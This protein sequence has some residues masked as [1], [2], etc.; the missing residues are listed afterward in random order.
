MLAFEQEKYPSAG[1]RR[2]VRHNNRVP[3][4]HCK[5]LA[6]REALRCYV[7]KKTIRS[8]QL[9]NLNSTEIQSRSKDYLCD[10]FFPSPVE[11]KLFPGNVILVA[12]FP[13]EPLRS[14]I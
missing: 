8:Q 3:G 2:F 10:V 1:R 11:Q 12:R 6:Q 13:I 4:A 14:N 5:T 9:A 7:E